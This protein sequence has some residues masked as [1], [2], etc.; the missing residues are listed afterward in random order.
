M[1]QVS[2]RT[3]IA[4]LRSVMFGGLLVSVVTHAAPVLDIK[5]LGAPAEACTDFD[6]F[7]NGAW[8]K[9]V[10]IPPDRGRIGTFDTVRD[11]AR[12]TLEQALT[13][14]VRAP[15]TLD[16]PGK[17]LAA[18]FYASG[19][20][21]AGITRRGLEAAQPLL[22][23]ID[24]LRERSQLPTVIAKL[25]RQGIDA[26]LRVFV[27]PDAK[28]RRRY[29]L[30]IDQGGLGLPD[31][32]DYVR[33]DARARALRAGYEAYAVRLASLGGL[34]DAAATAAADYALQKDFAGA[35]QSRVERRDPNAVYQLNT[36]ATLEQRAPGMDWK[37]FFA[38]LGVDDLREFSVASPG[39]VV[40]VARSAA[41]A[42]LATWRAYLTMRVLDELA[43]VLPAEWVTARFEYRGKVVQGLQQNVSRPEQVIRVIT[44][45]FGTEPLAEG[46][47]ELYVARAFTPEAKARALQMIADINVAMRARIE[48]VDWMSAPT[49]QRALH[50]L[51]AMAVKIGYPN[52]WKDYRGLVIENDDY[53]GNWLRARAW[54]FDLRLGDLGKPVDRARWF[55]TPSL[56][57]AFA[58]PLNEIIFPAAILQPPFFYP[59]ADDAVNYGGIGAVIGHEVT[60]HFDDRGRQFDSVGNLNDWWTSEDAA[61]Y[62]A[63]AARLAQQYSGFAPLP[64]QTINGQ[65]TLGENISDLGGVEVAYEALQIALARKAVGLIDGLAP[66]QRFFISFATIWRGQYRNESLLDALRTDSHS[67]V[68]YR[69]MGTLP[70]VP[71]FG[72]AFECPAGSPMTRAP[73]DRIRIW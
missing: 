14:A 21:E 43:P 31:R 28:D 42:P 62:Q 73:A 26:P 55:T 18:A 47:G 45:Q 59:D 35:S 33:D 71:A 50:K 70:N 3:K 13:D 1:L 27:T 24:A 49:K 61:A 2:N 25:A 39:F 60:H 16:T 36:L 72:K 19:I 37:K 56:V 65:L 32:D 8:K 46:L 29:L 64:G 15:Q 69:L 6:E 44:G 7:V 23:E 68:R 12:T 66:D 53:A 58:G 9:A 41:D 5:G 67:P 10:P 38:A 48:R 34:K 57:N 17:R 40:A 54:F 30:T 51:D 22:R 63:R 52:G 11:Q 4:M 20:D